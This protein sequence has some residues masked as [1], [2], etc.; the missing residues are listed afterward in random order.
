[1][2][3]LKILFLLFLL[4]NLSFATDK[5]IENIFKQHNLKGTIVISTLDNKKTYIYNKQRANKGYLP[6]STF[7]IPNTMIALQEKAIKDEYEIIKWD[8]KKR[9]YPP[10]NK[11]QTLQSALQYSCVWCYQKL[12]RKIGSKKYLHYLKE[13]N[14]GNKKTGK[15]LTTF[16][17]EGYI[18]ISALEQVEFLKKFYKNKLPFKQKYIDIT[19]KILTVKKTQKYTIKAKTGWSDTPIYGVGWYV[20]YVETK[21]DIYFFALNID[22]ED[23]SQLKYRTQIVNDVLK[24]KGIIN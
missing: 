4:I 7:K 11:D 10:W 9:F 17:L 6:A 16:W 15:E 24:I 19:K 8:G 1:M 12:A 23:K 22:I 5:Q 3:Y 18:R 2:K 13:L 20:G 21:K 14:Y